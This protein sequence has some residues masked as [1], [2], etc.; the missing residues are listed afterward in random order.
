MALQF[1]KIQGLFTKKK[2]KDSRSKKKPM[3][4]MILEK[5]IYGQ[6]KQKKKKKI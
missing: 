4:Y 6:A 1:K 2:K 3:A 5:R